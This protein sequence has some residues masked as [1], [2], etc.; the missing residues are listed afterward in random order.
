M[1]LLGAGRL[2]EDAMPIGG[3]TERIPGAS[4]KHENQIYVSGWSRM[5]FGS[6]AGRGQEP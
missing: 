4:N 3:V 2:V 1:H 5:L 6:G